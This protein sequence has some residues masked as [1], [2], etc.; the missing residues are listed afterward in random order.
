M[1]WTRR[2]SIMLLACAVVLSQAVS[3]SAAGK[4]EEKSGGAKGQAKVEA[5]GG[6][7]KAEKA[8]KAELAGETEQDCE[9]VEESVEETVAVSDDASQS[10]ENAEPTPEPEP[11]PETEPAPCAEKAPKAK[12]NLSGKGKSAQRNPNVDA[13]GNLVPGAVS[14]LT[15]EEKAARIA[16][17]KASSREMAKAERAKGEGGA[18]LVYVNGE[19]LNLTPVARS[20]RTLVPFRKLAEHLGATVDWEPSTRTVIMVKGDTRVEISI[21]ATT[22]MVN[23]EVVEVQA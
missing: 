6:G 18:Y 8:G 21:G 13:S 23:G 17:V 5:K 20:G 7:E 10:D 11:T 4:G 12:V 15:P 9:P 16:E 14:K 2:V 1:V 22:A 3:V 19:R